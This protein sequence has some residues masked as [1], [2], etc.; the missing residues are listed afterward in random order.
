MVNLR[1][2]EDWPDTDNVIV[3]QERILRIIKRIAND[4]DELARARR[5]ADLSSS[6]AD[7]NPRLFRRRQLGE[8]PIEA[9]T[10]PM[11]IPQGHRAW[12]KYEKRLKRAGLPI[13]ENPY[14][15][16][17]VHKSERLSVRF[18]PFRELT[19]LSTT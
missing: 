12:D 18:Y 9:P 4:I 16:L 14:R 7:V 15:F 19:S 13:P 2:D 10:G 8:A 1:P 5:V 3:D 11:S 6:T 17:I